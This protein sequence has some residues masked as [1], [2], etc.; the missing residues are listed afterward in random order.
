MLKYKNSDIPETTK[1]RKE[2]S[3]RERKDHLQQNDRIPRSP[4]KARRQW[5]IFK[6]C[7]EK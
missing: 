4:M 3:Q 2:S 7:R 5:Y 1:E 6:V